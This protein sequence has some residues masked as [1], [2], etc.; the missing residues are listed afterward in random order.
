MT[1]QARVER[2]TRRGAVLILLI[3]PVS[4]CL[5]Q[6]PAPNAR[7]L[8]GQVVAGAASITQTPAVTQITQSSAHAGI[9]WQG[10]DIGRDHTVNFV[11]PSASAVALNRVTGPDPSII[12]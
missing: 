3:L 5:A 4:P 12:A 9:D 6:S 11:Q 1:A 8:G 10:F 7:P 2:I